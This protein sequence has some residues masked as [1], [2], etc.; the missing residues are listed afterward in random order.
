MKG[1]LFMKKIFLVGC[2]F[3]C[4]NVFAGCTQG[5]ETSAQSRTDLTAEE[6]RGLTADMERKDVEDLLGQDDDHLAQ[7]ED[8]DVYS[9]SDGSTAILRYVDDKLAGAY[10]RG[11]D[12][13]ED[14]IFSK[15]ARDIQENLDEGSYNTN[16]GEVL[17]NPD[18]SGETMS[19]TGETALES[20]SR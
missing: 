16:D 10:I 5:N 20:Q 19:Q 17:G 6:I 18:E 14:T 9:L 4:L 7:K 15:F 13:F 8:V 12:M 11:K 3:L 2:L 1:C